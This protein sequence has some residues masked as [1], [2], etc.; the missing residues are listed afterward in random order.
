MHDFISSGAHAL[1]LT[2]TLTAS[3]LLLND[4][5]HSLLSCHPSG[6]KVTSSYQAESECL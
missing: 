5:S 2:S 6:K 4:P 3:V 1:F